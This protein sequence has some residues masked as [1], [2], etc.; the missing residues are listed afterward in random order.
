MLIIC[1]R[2]VRYLYVRFPFNKELAQKE[3]AVSD[4]N[5]HWTLELHLEKSACLG[6][7]DR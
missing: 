5:G 6:S 1:F 3:K 2:L 4:F 7:D